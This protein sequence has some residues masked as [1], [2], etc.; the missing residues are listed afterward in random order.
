M[1]KRWYA[2][3][4]IPGYEKRVKAALEKKIVQADKGELFGDII[5]PTEKV[6]DLVRGKKQTVERRLYPGY[7]LV[8]MAYGPEAW[9][10]VHSVPRVLGIV[11]EAAGPTE[12]PEAEVAEIRRQMELG[13]ATP[14][15]KFAFHVGEK[16]KV[17]DGPFREFTGTVE[18]VRPERSRLRVAISVFGRPTPVELDF[19]QVEAA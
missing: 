3:Y 2:V 14:R 1:E 19:T 13:H 4:T 15:P 12:I 17:I 11:G 16:V 10:V 6:I 8:Q 7:V 18:D 5:V 9:H